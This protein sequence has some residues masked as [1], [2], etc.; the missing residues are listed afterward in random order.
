MQFTSP[1]CKNDN[2]IFTTYGDPIPLKRH[3]THGKRTYDPSARD[4]RDWL[5]S[6]HSLAP[7]EPWA[8]PVVLDV[9]FSLTQ[10]AYHYTAKGDIKERYLHERPTKRPDLSNMLKFIEDAMNGVFYVDD[11]QIVQVSM[12]KRWH[13]NASSTVRLSR[14]QSL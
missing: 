9:V 7:A 13:Q 4:K 3:R 6:I 1:S 11:S 8:G 5:A 10:P 14:W 12:S 2:I